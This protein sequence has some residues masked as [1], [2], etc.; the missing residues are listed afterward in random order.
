MVYDFPFFARGKYLRAAFFAK[1]KPWETGGWLNQD[2]LTFLFFYIDGFARLILGCQL[3][4]SMGEREGRLWS[5]FSFWVLGRFFFFSGAF[6]GILGSN[7]SKAVCNVR[8][9]NSILLLQSCHDL[10]RRS[11]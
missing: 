10:W 4:P 11:P 5:R 3:E 8:M 6:F 1:V 2:V 7:G 9:E